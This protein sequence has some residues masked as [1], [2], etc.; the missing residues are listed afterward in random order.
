M[1]GKIKMSRELK[2]RCYG[3]SNQ[4]QANTMYY[5]DLRV[6]SPHMV[7]SNEIEQF[8]GLED[9]NGTEIY[10]GDI[11]KIHNH[12]GTGVVKFINHG[13]FVVDED[14]YYDLIYDCDRYKFHR[15][16][17]IIGNIHENP[18]LLK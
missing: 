9:K 5:F 16:P 13:Y 2:F 7:P 15:Q 1:G 14:E 11:L 8:T 6:G 17:E 12:G 10:E 4:L 18:E 3:W